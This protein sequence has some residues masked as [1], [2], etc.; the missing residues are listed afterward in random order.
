MTP[1]KLDYIC[2]KSV[3][4]QKKIENILNFFNIFTGNMIKPPQ[5]DTPTRYGLK[6]LCSIF[7]LIIDGIDTNI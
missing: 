6:N 2:H 7:G 1:K 3:E 5:S 4:L